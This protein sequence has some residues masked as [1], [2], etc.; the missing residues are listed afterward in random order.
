MNGSTEKKGNNTGDKGDTNKES[1]DFMLEE[2]RQIAKVY[3][4]TLTQKNDLL[5]F[6][7]A[8]IG[9]GGSLLA[10]LFKVTEND[11]EI[12]LI[13]L[14]S[15]ESFVVIGLLAVLIS[16]IGLI[17]FLSIVGLRIE[18]VLYIRTINVLRGYF[19]EK[20]KNITK[21]LVLPTYDKKTP[22]FRG[23]LVTS[24]CWVAVLISLI[25]SALLLSGSYMLTVGIQK[26]GHEVGAV[27]IAPAIFLFFLYFGIHHLLHYAM[28][29][30]MERT[31][32]WKRKKPRQKEDRG[33]TMSM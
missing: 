25:N 8:V 29:Y 14:L 26:L 9:T 3:G 20:D 6:Y 15:V 16:L 22:P 12:S 31:Y 28:T 23:S 33:T 10:V 11:P 2:Y 4:D 17:I 27:K 32:I 5:K 13:E 21:F 24:F 7:I 18:M 19:A 1:T 30:H